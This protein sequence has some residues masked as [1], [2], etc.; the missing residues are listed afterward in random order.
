[1]KKNITLIEHFKQKKAIP[2]TLVYIYTQFNII[3]TKP[4]IRW[5]FK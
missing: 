3:I 2:A 5:L 1:M 4:N